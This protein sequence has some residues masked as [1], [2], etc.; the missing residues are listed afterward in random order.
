MSIKTSTSERLFDVFNVL[1]MLFLIIIML[2]PFIYVI[3]ASISDSN[4]LM[5]HTGLLLTPQGFSLAAYKAVLE[6]P[7]IRSG[8]FNTIV[9]LLMAVSIN[10]VLTSLGAYGLSR[11]DYPLRRPFMLMITFTMFFSGGLIPNYLLVRDLGMVNTRYALFIPAAIS[12]WNLII[13]RTSFEGIPDSL[14]ESAKL[15]GAN[16]FLILR[17]IVIP[18]SMP[19]IAVMILFYG[20]ENWNSWFSAFIYLKDRTLWPLQLVLREIVI[21]NNLETMTTSADMADKAAVS[22]SIKYATVMVA[23]L[24]I[25]FVYPMLQKHFVKGVMIGAIKG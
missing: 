10:M 17:R 8:Y 12:V 18:V 22:E 4:Q 9:N 15:D 16:D 13:M 7:L 14:I 20:V 25:L 24:P 2:Y 11:K 19:V 3:F 6:N 21:A 1:F 23:T 5:R